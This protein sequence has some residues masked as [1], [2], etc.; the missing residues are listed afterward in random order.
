MQRL[1]AASL[2][3]PQKEARE[4]APTEQHIGSLFASFV[5]Y[6]ATG[7]LECQQAGRMEKETARHASE[8][9][10]ELVML[11]LAMPGFDAA[12][13]SYGRQILCAYL[14]A[15][16]R[17]MVPDEKMLSKLV[18]MALTLLTDFVKKKTN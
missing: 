6:I 7:I 18:E 9:M 12:A 17:S 10:A 16:P 11:N 13:R 3:S 2:P 15:P 8:T 1:E 5:G 14:A 4:P